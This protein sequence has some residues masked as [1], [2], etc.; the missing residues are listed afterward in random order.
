MSIMSFIKG[1]DIN[2]G[3]TEFR[4]AGNAVLIDVRDPGEYGMGHIPGSI[5]MPLNVLDARASEI[6]DKKTPVYV[7]CLTGAR[8]GTAV[9]ILKRQGFVNV[10]NIGGIKSFR[11]DLEKRSSRSF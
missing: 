6:K 11:G 2:S 7:Y 8:A 1:A 10:K 4:N 9:N 3:I 5:N